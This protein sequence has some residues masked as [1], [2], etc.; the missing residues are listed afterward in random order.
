M[1]RNKNKNK[2]K[3]AEAA[4][5]HNVEARGDA[6]PA[7][8]SDEA[9]NDVGPTPQPN[10]VAPSVAPVAAPAEADEPDE[11]RPATPPSP[12]TGDSSTEVAKYK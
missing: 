6:G 5:L 11:D 4:A 12:S 10:L 2:A 9:R 1:T 3:A 8:K 7:P